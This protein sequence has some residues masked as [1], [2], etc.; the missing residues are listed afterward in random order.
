MRACVRAPLPSTPS[1]SLPLFPL[2]AALQQPFA[3]PYTVVVT[4]DVMHVLTLSKRQLD[5]FLGVESS[6]STLESVL[7]SLRKSKALQV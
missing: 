7:Q 1:F 3:S 4:S 6:L 5:H 2:A